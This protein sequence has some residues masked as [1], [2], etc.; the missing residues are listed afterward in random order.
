MKS[1]MRRATPINN[2]RK[3][4]F[5]ITELMIAMTLGLILISGMISVFVST[6]R[7]SD[8]NSAVAN[9]QESA[10]YALDSLTREIRMAGFQGCLDISDTSV[11]I[12]ANNP[13]TTDLRLSLIGG[14]VVQASDQ[15]I[16]APPFPFTL[17][18]GSVKAV[19]GTHAV[20]V[21]SA[22]ANNSTVSGVMTSGGF[23]SM[24]GD[25]PVSNNLANLKAGDFAII[26]D[27]TTG[28]LFTVSD[29]PE[30]SGFV[31]HE[32][33][34]NVDGNLSKAYGEDEQLLSTRL[35]KFQSNV[36]FVGTEGQ[37]TEDG[38]QI[39]GLYV[40]TLP[41]NSSNPPVE[42][43]EGVENLR[44]RFGI[45]QSNGSLSYV[46]ADH[47]EYDSL[48]VQSVQVG[49]LM[50]SID[51][52]RST[53]DLQ[54]YVLAGQEIPA[55]ATDVAGDANAHSANRQYRLVFNTTTNLRNRRIGDN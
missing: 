23:T 33:A 13:P 22:S 21:Q 25:I 51:R 30:E 9:L 7:T 16:P 44:I 35:M 47:S 52:I 6:K 39:R 5:T 31:S 28:D 50:A 24:A 14:S 12:R 26:S 27:C 11:N 49:M 1:I 42:L 54:T 55:S 8:L 34:D 18:N 48:Q 4:G 20:F 40:Q 17:P 45:R 15:W 41:Y 46:T 2:Q 53:D 32:A 10:R 43:V 36:Y 3:R 38:D 19:P 37:T 29:A